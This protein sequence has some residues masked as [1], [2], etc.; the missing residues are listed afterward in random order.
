MQNLQQIIYDIIVKPSSE[1]F[2]EA[3]LTA[4]KSWLA[5]SSGLEQYPYCPY[6]LV[7]N[8]LLAT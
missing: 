8:A 3:K 5:P 6:F 4:K 2:H 1:K 7:D